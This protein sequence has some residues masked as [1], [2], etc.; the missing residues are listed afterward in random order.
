[1]VAWDVRWLRRER[2]REFE[3]FPV[4]KE[5]FIKA[6]DRMD[7]SNMEKAFRRISEENDRKGVVKTKLTGKDI[8]DWWMQDPRFYGQTELEGWRDGEE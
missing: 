7:K 2:E 6:F 4:Y 3:I 1:M 5:N 8:Y